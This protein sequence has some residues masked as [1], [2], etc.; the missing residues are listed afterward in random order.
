MRHSDLEQSAIENALSPAAK[1]VV[2]VLARANRDATRSGPAVQPPLPDNVGPVYEVLRKI[3]GGIEHGHDIKDAYP[4]I[5]RLIHSQEQRANVVNQLLMTNEFRRV[6]ELSA[7]R[8]HLE[9]DLIKAAYRQDLSPAE[10]LVLMKMLQDQLKSSEGRLAAGAQPVQ[11]LIGLMQKI[12]FATQGDEG[13]LK[14]RFSQ[15]SAQG[16]EIIRKL[17][18]TMKRALT[19]EKPGDA[20]LA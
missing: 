9:N 10:R 2:D 19:D 8:D 14:A 13:A 6:T 17:V 11:D 7:A 4:T 5:G 1:V 12:N 20:K 15:T 18:T 3:V 16:R